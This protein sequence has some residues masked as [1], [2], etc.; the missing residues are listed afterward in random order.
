MYIK[1]QTADGWRVEE[2]ASVTYGRYRLP[3]LGDPSDFINKYAPDCETHILP[4][5][6]S[7]AIIR[8]GDRVIATT[9]EAYLLNLSGD[10]IDKV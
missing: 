1:Y 3:V 10:T 6:T 4:K 5:P 7:V 9:G 8:T 2:H